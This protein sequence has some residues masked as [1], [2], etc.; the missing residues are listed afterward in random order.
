MAKSDT[1]GFIWDLKKPTRG[2]KYVTCLVITPM[3]A[4]SSR[5]ADV[6]N[7]LERNFGRDMALQMA[8][9]LLQHIGAPEDLIQQVEALRRVVSEWQ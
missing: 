7:N 2:E 3:R 5:G 8:S 1:R 4:D 6:A 9:E